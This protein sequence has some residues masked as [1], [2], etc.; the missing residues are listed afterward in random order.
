MRE[1]SLNR[2]TQDFL[3]CLTS[4]L[5]C[6]PVEISQLNRNGFDERQRNQKPLNNAWYETTNSI[7]KMTTMSHILSL[8]LVSVTHESQKYWSRPIN[9]STVYESEWSGF[10]ARFARCVTLNRLTP[11]KYWFV[12][13][14]RHS[15][16]KR[17][18]CWQICIV[19]VITILSMCNKDSQIMMSE[20]RWNCQINLLKD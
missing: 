9:F 3:E 7:E 4:I 18:L 2:R 12:S 15:S 16:C 6:Y 10:H 1:K 17:V 13:S 19:K 14:D 5:S 11:S 8:A 20:R